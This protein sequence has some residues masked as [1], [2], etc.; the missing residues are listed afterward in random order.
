M[1]DTTPCFV[2]E[3]HQALTEDQELQFINKYKNS[4]KIDVK[5][6]VVSLKM[7]QSKYK[8]FPWQKIKV[9]N[10]YKK[11]LEELI[12][13]HPKN[14]HLR[15]VRLVIQEKIPKMLNYYSEV[16]E[17]KEFLIKIMNEKDNADYLDTYIVKNTSL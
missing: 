1:V 5:A 11:H 17:D 6:Y 16:K 10:K 9:F 12:S 2:K 15:Y 14:V 8:F 3:Y 13:K 7:K 4:T